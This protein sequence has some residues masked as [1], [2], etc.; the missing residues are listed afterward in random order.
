MSRGE[1]EELPI[2]PVIDAGEPAA[3]VRDEDLPVLP[4]LEDERRS[5]VGALL[6]SIKAH[7]SGAP[8]AEGLHRKKYQRRSALQQ[9][10]QDVRSRGPSWVGSAVAHAF[11]L[12]VLAQFVMFIRHRDVVRSIL[13]TLSEADAEEAGESAQP[14]ER[15]VQQAPAPE[16]EPDEPPV[17]EPAEAA[18]EPPSAPEEQPDDRAVPS[19]PAAPE[20][21]PLEGR[22]EEIEADLP[23]GPA[24]PA[25]ASVPAA[26]AAP[27]GPKA[28][29]N[30]TGAG[31][32]QALNQYGGSAET[33][34]AVERGLR[35]LANHQSADGR[36]SG[37]LFGS[38]CP[39]P[40]GRWAGRSH[41]GRV[42]N[43]VACPSPGRA[44][45]DVAHTGLAT[46]CF[47]GAGH[48]PAST[49]Y[50]E[51][52]RKGLEFLTGAQ[53]HDGGFDAP[54]RHSCMYNHAIATLALCEA[55]ALTND[56]QLRVT[57]QRAVSYL[58]AAQTPTGG[59]DYT[60]E[61]V[62][63]R[64]SD[65]S[66]SAWAIM[67]MKSALAADLVVS[68]RSW[69]RAHTFV[70]RS[71]RGD[72]EYS[73]DTGKARYGP[74]M[75]AAGLVCDLYLGTDPELKVLSNAARRVA[76]ELPDWDRLASEH[77]HTVYYWY[78][79]SLAMFQWGGTSW[80]RWNTAMRTTLLTK[81]RRGG[82]ADGSWDPVGP[83]L[84][85]HG[86]RVYATAL[87]V[88]S[89]E[90]YYRYLPVYRM[91]TELPP[92]TPENSAAALVAS[93]A[94]SRLQPGSAPKPRP[95]HRPS[96]YQVAG[97]AD[98][99]VKVKADAPAMRAAAVGRLAK[100]PG[101]KAFAAIKRTLRD[102][103]QMVRYAAIQALTARAEPEA[104]WLMVGALGSAS[105]D[106]RR[107]VV[108]APGQHG[109]RAAVPS[110]IAALGDAD[111]GLHRPV[112]RALEQL[113]QQK[114]GNNVRAW[115]RWWGAQ[116]RK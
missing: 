111:R 2:L 12:L 84:G 21:Q 96:V 64:R 7:Q 74:A 73:Y 105:R 101:P 19:P 5:T 33:E 94:R 40:G 81:Q 77:D 86:G 25:E 11:V 41:S 63:T 104:T 14:D 65:M 87:N 92:D 1:T 15:G 83:W 67:A 4:V 88:L 61:G 24:A 98:A 59:W 99:L 113:T 30:R 26:P 9:L 80:T 112:E 34:E 22:A 75:T 70:R 89:L 32:A 95:V 18:E 37:A 49:R 28:F 85:S 55:V 56:P 39:S 29:H 62:R 107:V 36:W 23:P 68:R 110:L 97:A 79:G 76:R 116:G 53:R 13:I 20:P 50:G 54:S 35:W 44:G 91:G 82:H 90:V 115:R 78:Y 103:D 38:R 31:K 47:L 42:A 27:M 52:V 3:P 100:E 93:A 109:D 6:S 106:M 71:Q 114:F 8:T 46:L 51:Q 60:G 66:V 17:E 48:L 16:G 102:K 108:R 57:A 72:G 43:P 58:G 69:D 45:F 10:C